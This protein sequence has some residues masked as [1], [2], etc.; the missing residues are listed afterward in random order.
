MTSSK[1]CIGI[2]SGG[3]DEYGRSQREP[4][5]FVKLTGFAPKSR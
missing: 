4:E 5:G 1:N 2:F 3:D